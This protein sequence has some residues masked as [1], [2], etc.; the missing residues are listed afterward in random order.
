MGNLEQT[1]EGL[2]IIKP[3][4]LEAVVDDI[5]TKPEETARR[6]YERMEHNPL[7]K[8]HLKDKATRIAPA[9]RRKYLQGAMEVYEFLAMQ[10]ESDIQKSP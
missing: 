1:P 5:N 9:D 3:D 4:I 2:P 7:L 6:S 8:Q 10:G